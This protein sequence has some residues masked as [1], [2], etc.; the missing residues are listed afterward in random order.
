MCLTAYAR[1]VTGNSTDVTATLRRSA[2]YICPRLVELRLFS[3]QLALI[4]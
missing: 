3:T 4:S 1:R 2:G